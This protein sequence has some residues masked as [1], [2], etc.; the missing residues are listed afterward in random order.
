[1]IFHELQGSFL[2]FPTPSLSM[3]DYAVVAN[4]LSKGFHT[5]QKAAGLSGSL[6]S[7][8]HP[9]FIETAAVDK[10]SFSIRP[11]ERVGFLGPNGAGKSTTI[12]MLVGILYP[13]SGS[14]RVLGHV[15]WKD[16]K[17]LAFEIGSVF[18]QKPQLWYHLPPI[19]TF[20]L[21]SK[22]YELDEREYK[23]RLDY[24]VNI[25][26]IDYLNIPVRKL[27]LGQ[28]MKAE[29]VA[30]LLHKPKVLFL[31]EPTIGLDIIAKQKIRDLIKQ[32]NAEE[33]V[34]IFLTSHDMDDIEKVCKRVIII[35][36]GA[37]VFDGSI[38][39]LKSRIQSKVVHVKFS[40]G[41]KFPAFEG[42]EIVSQTAY[43]VEI[44]L[45]LRVSRIAELLDYISDKYDV[46]DINV[47]DPK[48]EE[49]IAEI[50]QR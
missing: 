38:E 41:P 14:A 17:K 20:N 12:K 42:A 5:K 45:D 1:M 44:K 8:F 11:G 19:D 10:I 43:S 13:D 31:D 48:I 27:S 9:R 29:I 18:G 26:G 4:N 33:G 47:S 6:A 25:F 2:T 40:R 22:I 28:R 16:R 49:I 35:N 23:K 34:S 7:L 36:K 24:L 46:L 32:L 15:P 39:K 37:L 21:M 50:Y 3:K 30:S